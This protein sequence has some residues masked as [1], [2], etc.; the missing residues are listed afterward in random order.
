MKNE[1]FKSLSEQAREVDLLSYLEQN[2]CRIEKSGHEYYVKDTPSGHQLCIH[3][4]N[5]QWYD[6]YTNIGRTNNSIDCLVH[7]FGYSFN[8][9]VYALTGQDI[10]TMKSSDFPKKSAPE[11]TYPPKTDRMKTEKKE[12]KMPEQAEKMNRLF[13]YLCYT[14]KIPCP[15][16][17]ALVH[18]KLLYQSAKNGNAVFVHR[19]STGKVTGGEIQGTNSYKRFKGV[20]AGTGDSAFTY[21]PFPTPDGKPKRA[22][23][24]ESA[25]DMMSFLTFCK[26]EKMKGSMF[27][28]MGGLKPTIPKRLEA[29]GAE[30]I[31]CVDND[32]AGRRFEKENNFQRPDGIKRNLDDLGF[33]DW[34]ELLVFKSENPNANLNTNDEQMKSKGTPLADFFLSRR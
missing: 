9:A 26:V 16:V 7:V 33:K 5:N 22:Y 23:I 4:D 21:M 31:S 24:F 34:N 12:L 6:H 20:V 17:E 18:E 19:D 3:P 10:T 32:D 1:D 28:S 2:G 11:Y 29:E 27:V 8:Q 13:A 25:I 30:I 15:I 14:R